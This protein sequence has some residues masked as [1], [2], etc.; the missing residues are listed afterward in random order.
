V[1]E[2]NVEKFDP[3]AATKKWGGSHTSISICDQTPVRP[4][5]EDSFQQIDA[6]PPRSTCAATK[7]EDSIFFL[8]LILNSFVGIRWLFYFKRNL[9]N[10]GS[11]QKLS[12]V[13][14]GSTSASRCVAQVPVDAATQRW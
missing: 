8:I 2:K 12:S 11:W 14:S 9:A 13:M 3:E 7:H 4:S 1:N 6:S 10:Y 5:C